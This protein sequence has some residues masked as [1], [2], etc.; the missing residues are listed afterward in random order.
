MTK[1]S[2]KSAMRFANPSSQ[3]FSPCRKRTFSSSTSSP[4]AT[5]TPSIQSLINRTSRPSSFDSVSATG[6][7]ENSAVG[8][9]SVGRP[10]CDMTIT[11]A[12]PS[13][14][15]CNVGKAARIRASLVTFPA[16]T[17][18]LRSSRMSTRLPDRSRSVMLRAGMMLPILRYAVPAPY[19]ACGSRNPIRCRTRH[20]L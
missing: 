19:R 6:C 16:L 4:G 20:R 9:P 13:N 12:F 17:G 14:A 7:N 3:S 15:C 8:S 2:H 18:T 1:T 11:A 10:R 5:S